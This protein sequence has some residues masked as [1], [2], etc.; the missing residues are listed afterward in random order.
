MLLVLFVLLPVV[1]WSHLH[2][3]GWMYYRTSI[4]G[5][6]WSRKPLVHRPFAEPLSTAV[7][8]AEY[9]QAW[10]EGTAILRWKWIG[11]HHKNRPSIEVQ[12]LDK[13]PFLL[14]C[15]VFRFT[16]DSENS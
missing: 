5:D 3:T 4:A 2:V 8:R 16:E 9:R 6:A 11:K 13:N 7:K 1:F 12:T 14:F 15:C 10:S